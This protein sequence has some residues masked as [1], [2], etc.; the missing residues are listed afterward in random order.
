VVEINLCA[1]ELRRNINFQ[2]KLS[3][4]FQ[5]EIDGQQEKQKKLKI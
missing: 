5:N 3:Y 1:K 4:I 2:A